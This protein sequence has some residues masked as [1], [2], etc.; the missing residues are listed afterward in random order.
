MV[1]CYVMSALQLET[2]VRH[3]NI[4]RR[5]GVFVANFV[6]VHLHYLRA[7]VLSDYPTI[8]IKLVLLRCRR[9]VHLLQA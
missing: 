4:C 8:H 9:C 6:H 1:G 7:V 5:E 2:V 3:K